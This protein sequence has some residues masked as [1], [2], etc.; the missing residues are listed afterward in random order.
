[1]LAVGVDHK[2]IE[3]L[4]PAELDGYVQ[5]A[6]QISSETAAVGI[7]G[8]IQVNESTTVQM[9]A[10]VAAVRQAK[11]DGTIYAAVSA[12][13]KADPYNLDDNT[14]ALL[15]TEGSEQH[16]TD[17]S[18]AAMITHVQEDAVVAQTI[19]QNKAASQTDEGRQVIKGYLNALVETESSEQIATLKALSAQLQSVA[20]FRQG[21]KDYTSG[22]ATAYEGS[23]TLLDGMNQ[24]SSGAKK[25]NDG[26]ATLSQGA[27]SLKDGTQSLTDGANQLSDGAKTLYDGLVEY[28]DEG[29]SKLTDDSRI[30]S[31]EDASNLLNAVK[32]QGSAYN[33]Y[34][35]ISEGTDGSV[36]FVFKVEGV[37]NTAT[38]TATEE[39]TKTKTSF[40][41]RIVNLFDFLSLFSK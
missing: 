5:A 13:L 34:S 1:M 9:S 16:A 37:K 33:N 36:K 35:G 12:I 29:I 24:L 28:N 3:N 17:T 11:G 18:L 27:S 15:L 32:E 41:D 6:L 39:T 10:V 7:D 20:T 19:A 2:N 31:L 4:T 22:V 26:A 30:S 38:S 14:I 25:L 40:W 21:V 8:S 23:K